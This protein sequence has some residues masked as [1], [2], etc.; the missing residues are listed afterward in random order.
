MGLF[1]NYK[2]NFNN[3]Y[4]QPA[5]KA[6]S[7]FK[8]KK[9][10]PQQQTNFQ[11]E[12]Q[13]DFARQQLEGNKPKQPSFQQ[14]QPQQPN[15][16]KGIQDRSQQRIDLQKKST[17]D[18]VN[19]IR[20]SGQ[21]GTQA[22]QSQI[23]AL[24]GGYDKYV[25][26]VRGGLNRSK[27]ATEGAKQ[28]TE[29]VYG[30]A[31]R[32]GAEGWRATQGQI[33][34]KFANLNAVDSSAYQNRYVNAGSDF[35]RGQQ[36]LL[37]TQAQEIARLDSEYT[38]AEI[39]AEQLI[40]VESTNLQQQIA[41]I[42]GSIAQGTVEYEQAIAD[43]YNNAQANIFDIQ[44]KLSTF[45]ND[46][47]VE[48]QKAD[49]EGNEGQEKEQSD[50]RDTIFLIDEIL[51]RDLDPVT[52]LLRIRGSIRG[53]EAFDTKA[54]LEQLRNKLALAARGQL[55]GQGTVSDFEAEML[56]NAVAQLD[57]GQSPEAITTELKRIRANASSLTGGGQSEGGTIRVRNLQTGET[58]SLPENEFDP[59]LYERI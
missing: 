41:Q 3:L 35:S 2:Q 8:R 47:E 49:L 7:F 52:G 37:G 28:N 48:R 56:M 9:E 19:R 30:G 11:S 57:R 12:A 36:E 31:L 21:A 40:N 39:D 43:A 10:E 50:A 6:F 58:G 46:I 23:P 45:E 38:Q 44:D 4:V 18:Y 22:L 5:K 59:R 16:L 29:N 14:P 32:Q 33:D 26:G 1:S 27:V 42:Q 13:N 55:K 24:Q 20:T 15:Y 51:S 17:D 34:K 25:E 54:K 53:T